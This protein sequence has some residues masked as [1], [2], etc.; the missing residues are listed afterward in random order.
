MKNLAL[1][2]LAWQLRRMKE[3]STWAG[4]AAIIAGL[5]SG[6]EVNSVA[7]VLASVASVGAGAL[8]VFMTEKGVSLPIESP[9]DS[10]K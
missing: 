2:L 8:A 10:S 3:P 5:W 9:D 6:F 4:T 7:N 1:T